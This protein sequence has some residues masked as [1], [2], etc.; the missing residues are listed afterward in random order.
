MGEI[1]NDALSMEKS[2][3]E[4]SI[5]K[6]K[7]TITEM[8]IPFSLQKILKMTL[9]FMFDLIVLIQMFCLDK[10]SH[11]ILIMTE[12]CSYLELNTKWLKELN[13]I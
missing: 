7:K 4:K 11:G 10:Q 5:M 2:K 6:E 1:L 9:R 3:M 12:G 8:A 13:L